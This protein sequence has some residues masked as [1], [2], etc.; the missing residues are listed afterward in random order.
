M[1][2]GRDEGADVS[3]PS[4]QLRLSTA[5]VVVRARRHGHQLATSGLPD[6]ADHPSPLTRK[7][8]DCPRSSNEHR[9]HGLAI[10]DCLS[11]V[12]ASCS[13]DNDS[14]RGKCDHAVRAINTTY[15]NADVKWTQTGT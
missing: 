12:D 2:V 13:T 10:M 1:V 6:R 7:Q 4:R 15:D 5:G 8:A 11:F 14:S 9:V 3:L